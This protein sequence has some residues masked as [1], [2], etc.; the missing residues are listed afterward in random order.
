MRFHFAA[1]KCCF[2]QSRCAEPVDQTQG[3]GGGEGLVTGLRSGQRNRI[4]HGVCSIE[5]LRESILGLAQAKEFFT[6]RIFDHNIRTAAEVLTFRNQV[7]AQRH[8]Q[9]QGIAE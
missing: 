6:K 1:T 7:I 5:K 4:S 9:G 2:Q 8:A 3:F